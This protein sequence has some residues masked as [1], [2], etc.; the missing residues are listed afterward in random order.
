MIS[1]IHGHCH[2]GDKSRAT[3]MIVFGGQMI[4]MYDDGKM[5]EW[6]SKVPK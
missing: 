1:S 5:S 2:R 4:E 3:R 6:P